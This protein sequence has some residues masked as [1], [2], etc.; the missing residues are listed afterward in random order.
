MELEKDGLLGAHPFGSTP[1]D[2]DMEQFKDW[3]MGLELVIG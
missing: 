2:Q 3:I 1:P